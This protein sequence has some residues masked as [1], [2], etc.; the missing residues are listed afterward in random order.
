[1]N[2]S[3]ESSQH[4]EWKDYDTSFRV[5]CFYPKSYNAESRYEVIICFD[6]HMYVDIVY[7]DKG[8]RRRMARQ[9]KSV[10]EL[11]PPREKR[12]LRPTSM[13]LAH[14]W[15]IMRHVVQSCGDKRGHVTLCPLLAFHKG[16]I[17]K[18]TKK[19]MSERWKEHKVPL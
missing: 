12:E 4:I 13:R 7:I 1:M 18:L 16:Q 8:T 17:K 2:Y 9:R 15:A 19:K 5:L 14:V 10:H 3:N 11:F 6:T